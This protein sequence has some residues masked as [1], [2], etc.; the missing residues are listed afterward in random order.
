[1][2]GIR[3]HGRADRIDQLADGSLAIVDYK[4]GQPP[5]V[6]MVAEGFALQLGLIGLIARGGG[7]AGVAGEPDV[8]EYWSLSKAK[9]GAFGWRDEPLKIGR[10]RT[11]LLREEFLDK[12][13]E[14]LRD[15]IARWILGAEPFTARLNPDIGGYNDYDQLMRLDEWL[16][17]LGGEE[18]AQ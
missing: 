14:Y 12:S 18:A 11:G 8:F 4:T 15:A 3:I 9:D 2:D 6:R 16:G 10:R 13:E 1:V 17:L 5:S 7:F